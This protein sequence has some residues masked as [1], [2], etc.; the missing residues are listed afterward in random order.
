MPYF[1]PIWLLTHSY[2]AS[3]F[4][5]LQQSQSLLYLNPQNRFQF[6]PQFFMDRSLG[7]NV[8]ISLAS[9]KKA[10]LVCVNPRSYFFV[11]ILALGVAAALGLAFDLVADLGFA[12]VFA[13]FLAV[14]FFEVSE[15]S[16]EDAST[17]S[18]A[19]PTF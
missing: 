7:K 3:I 18:T 16:S 15:L 6:A 8:L 4:L 1:L 11:L 2:P 9:L 12:F 19:K 14:T 13:G 17:V 10:F 5:N